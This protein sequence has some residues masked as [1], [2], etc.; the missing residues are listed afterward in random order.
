VFGQAIETG[1]QI[2]GKTGNISLYFRLQ[3][4]FDVFRYGEGTQKLFGIRLNF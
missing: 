4:D 1:L 3:D 2:P